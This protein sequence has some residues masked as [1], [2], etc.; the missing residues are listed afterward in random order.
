VPVAVNCFVLPATT[1]GFTGVTAIETSVAA[2][3]VSVVEPE[4]LPEVALIV[5]VPACNA[6]ARPVGL[7]VPVVVFVE[8]HVTVLVRFCV[9]LSEYVAVAVNCCV[10]PGATDGLAGVTAI[11]TSVAAVTVR[12]VELVTLAEVALIVVVPA[13]DAA[14]RPDALIVPVA[15]LEE[16]HSTLLVR[17]CVLLSE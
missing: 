16:A 3:T 9:L 12:V 4:T 13:F 10:V 15:V 14:A 8:D 17:F 11:E 5:V 6:E 7:I 1:D 2:L